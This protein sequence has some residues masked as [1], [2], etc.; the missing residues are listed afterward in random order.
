MTIDG[1]NTGGNALT[2]SNTSTSASASTIQ[3]IT[4]ATNNTVQNCKFMG[5]GISTTLGV[6]VL[7][8][9]TTGNDTNVITG[10]TITSA[11]ANLPANAIYS[12]GLSTSADN[13]GITI[14]NNNISD[15][16][17]VGVLPTVF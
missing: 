5:S 17:N 4:D 13:S 2:I 16:F 11:G 6:I 14:S 12:A 8:G 7:T 9:T 3:F 15:Y 1:L 10:N